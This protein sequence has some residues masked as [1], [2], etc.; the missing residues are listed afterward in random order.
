MVETKYP[1]GTPMECYKKILRVIVS[2]HPNI[3]PSVIISQF[4]VV[5]I[6]IDR[7]DRMYSNTIELDKIKGFLNVSKDLR[8][9]QI[10]KEIQDR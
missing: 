9:K 10:L 1:K 7:F 5:D 6:L 3:D 4:N 2:I 8:K